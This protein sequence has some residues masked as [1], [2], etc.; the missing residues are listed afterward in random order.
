MFDTRLEPSAL[1]KLIE[2]IK[3][4]GASPALAAVLN[5]VVAELPDVATS[6]SNSIPERYPAA[7][8]CTTCNCVAADG[9]VP[10]SVAAA[11][12][13]LRAARTKGIAGTCAGAFPAIG[14]DFTLIAICGGL[15]C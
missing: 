3:L 11:A 6:T 2:L 14:F 9:T 4:H 5:A 15:S 13:F 7:G 10:V 8:T 12:L 1:T